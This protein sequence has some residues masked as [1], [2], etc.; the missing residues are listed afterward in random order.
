M[1]GPCGIE[2]FEVTIAV[3]DEAIVT[4]NEDITICEGES[5]N[6]EAIGNSIGSFQW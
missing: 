3:A 5:T 1:T 4:V 2:T 6:L